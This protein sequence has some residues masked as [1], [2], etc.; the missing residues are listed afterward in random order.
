MTVITNAASVRIGIRVSLA[1]LW[2]HSTCVRAFFRN[3]NIEL[4]L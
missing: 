3:L 1:V 2:R 4:V